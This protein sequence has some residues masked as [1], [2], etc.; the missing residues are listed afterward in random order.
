MRSF[1]AVIWRSQQ[2]RTRTLRVH[3]KA[4]QIGL[5]VG[6][7]PLSIADNFLMAKRP[8]R[9]KAITFGAKKL[10]TLLFLSMI[11]FRQCCSLQHSSLL[12][13]YPPS[14]CIPSKRKRFKSPPNAC[15]P[16]GGG[17]SE[18][19]DGLVK[20]ECRKMR[21]TLIRTSPAGA[22]GSGPTWT[23]P[24]KTFSSA[25]GF[26]PSYTCRRSGQQKCEAR[27]HGSLIE[28]LSQTE[29]GTRGPGSERIADGSDQQ[30]R[31]PGFESFNSRVCS[32]KIWS[33]R[34]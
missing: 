11:A 5:R 4:W 23:Q 9:Q 6:G 27:V 33:L 7:I 14:L 24:R 21:V 22:G 34:L 26:S 25:T 15:S 20:E 32:T 17:L 31:S 19:L 16:Q 18:A 8:L 13:L 29:Q 2:F 28:R 12:F 3:G 30:W 10:M 1:W